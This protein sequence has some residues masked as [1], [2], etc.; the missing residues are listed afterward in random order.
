MRLLR[1]CPVV[2]VG[3]I[4]VYLKRVIARI[5]FTF[6]VPGRLYPF[7]ALN[8]IKILSF[9]Q[10]ILSIQNNDLLRRLHIDKIHKMIFLE[11]KLSS[12]VK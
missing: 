9:S 1:I 7:I 12:Q 5:S 10:A 11:F 3:R 4:V 2:Y 8:V 6:N